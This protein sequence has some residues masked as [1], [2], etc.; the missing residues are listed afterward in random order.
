MQNLGIATGTVVRVVAATVVLGLVVLVGAK[1][2]KGSGSKGS[3]IFIG[4]TLLGMISSL[5]KK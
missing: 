5:G 3:G 4:S 2:S 1:G